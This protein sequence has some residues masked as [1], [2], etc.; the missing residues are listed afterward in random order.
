MTP[1]RFK[2]IE[3]LY[4]SACERGV[5]VLEGTD[6]ELRREVERLLAEDSSENFL[7]KGME[8]L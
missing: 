1:E 5:A 8:D 7:D 3:A 4:H 6:P 2:Q